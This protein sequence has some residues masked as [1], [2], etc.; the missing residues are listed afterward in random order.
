M[1][2]MLFVGVGDLEH[3]RCGAPLSDRCLSFENKTSD[4]RTSM[5]LELGSNVLATASLRINRLLY[6]IMEFVHRNRVIV[7]PNAPDRNCAGCGAADRRSFALN[8]LKSRKVV[9]P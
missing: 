2:P 4:P 5:F 8:E 9:R 7:M 1:P 3:V 6:V